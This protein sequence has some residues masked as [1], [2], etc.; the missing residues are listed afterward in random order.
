[1]TGCASLLSQSLLGIERTS[2]FAAHMSA[3]DPKR[4]WNPSALDLRPTRSQPQTVK[5]CVLGEDFG[6]PSQEEVR[7]DSTR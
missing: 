6:E 1:M 2:L 4:T 7:H 5:K 3:S